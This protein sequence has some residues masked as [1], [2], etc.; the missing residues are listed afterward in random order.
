MS[1]TVPP[2]PADGPVWSIIAPIRI[3]DLSAVA[4]GSVVSAAALLA[5]ASVDSVSTGAVS[6]LT[7]VVSLAASVVTG[8]SVV[9]GAAVVAADAVVVVDSSSLPHADA[10]TVNTTAHAATP[11]NDRDRDLCFTRYPHFL[12]DTAP[13]RS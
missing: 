2:S 3:G 10:T 6:G 8:A 5:G 1:G 4:A 13:L 7:A 11:R 9:P 12:D